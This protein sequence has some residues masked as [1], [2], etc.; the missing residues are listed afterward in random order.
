MFDRLEIGNDCV[1]V[2]IDIP[3]QDKHPGE[4][5]E[6]VTVDFTISIVD[7]ATGASME[8]L[9]NPT[10]G[11]FRIN[12]EGLNRP[13]P[14]LGIEIFNTTGQLVQSK[15]LVRYD[16]VYTAQLSLAAYPAGVYYVRFEDTEI[17]RM[18]RIVKQ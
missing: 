9:P 4:F 6:L 8:V 16:N 5:E 12:V 18:L 17:K 15:S 7:P 2:N 14:F 10:N 11:V 1:V 13:S 3:G